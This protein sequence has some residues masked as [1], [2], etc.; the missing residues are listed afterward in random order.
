MRIFL[1]IVGTIGAGK[2]NAS[3]YLVN[4]YSFFKVHMGNLVRA[5]A[6][7]EKIKITR[8]N[9][10]RLQEKYH[11]KYGKEFLIN[12]AINKARES[13]KQK[14]IISGI[15]TPEQ[16]ARF[17]K[18]PNAKIIFIDA[19]PKLR[20]ERLKKRKRK[21]FPKTLKEFKKQEKNEERYFKFNKILRYADYKIE[22]NATEKDLY[23][24]LDNLIR[25]LM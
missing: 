18:E 11:K 9:L 16:A 25:K 4:H 1:G 8:E 21:G 20:F 6:R 24:K 19:K 22:N 7:K 10:G 13:K 23:K 3:N 2:D 17:K 5:L 14:V 12:A 15:R